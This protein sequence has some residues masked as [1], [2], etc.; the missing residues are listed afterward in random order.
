MVVGLYYI[1][2]LNYYFKINIFIHTENH[3]WLSVTILT[4]SLLCAQS[5]TLFALF[6]TDYL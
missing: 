3:S 6:S 4:S 2:N 5:Y 1:L